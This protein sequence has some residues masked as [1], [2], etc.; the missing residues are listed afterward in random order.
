MKREELQPDA[1]VRG[2]LPEAA[3][4]VVSVAGP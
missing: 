4:T 2:I 1:A 3:V